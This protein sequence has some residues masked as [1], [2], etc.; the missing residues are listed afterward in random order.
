MFFVFFEL[1]FDL[2]I[3]AGWSGWGGWAGMGWL[4]W[5]GLAG[6]GWLAW[7]GGLAGWVGGWLGGFMDVSA[8]MYRWVYDPFVPC[9]DISH[10]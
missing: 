5:D 3:W 4:V 8:H 9:T 2:V 1:R 7:L 6:L 10:S